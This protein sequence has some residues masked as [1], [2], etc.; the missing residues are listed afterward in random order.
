MCYNFIIDRNSIS[1]VAR[2][3]EQHFDMTF[4]EEFLL[5]LCNFQ[6]VQICSEKGL[7]TRKNSKFKGV[8]L[9]N[10]NILV[11]H[12]VMTVVFSC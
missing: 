8:Y 10:A 1:F 7:C 2:I 9:K 11:F 3:L 12:Y 5:D 6:D 4:L